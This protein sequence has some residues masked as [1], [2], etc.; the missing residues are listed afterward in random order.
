MARS[1]QRLARWSVYIL[2]CGDGSLYTGVS[3]DVAARLARHRA[4][5][6]AA[7]TRSRRPLQLVHVEPGLTRSQALRREAAIKRLPRAS[8][9][10]LIGRRIQPPA[11]TVIAPRS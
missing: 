2:C 7:Y 9:L 11:P 3:V 6:G 8:K 5:R 4:G 1:T 10:R